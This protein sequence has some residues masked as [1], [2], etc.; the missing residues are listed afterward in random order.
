M[1][2]GAEEQG[3]RRV[4]AVSVVLKLSMRIHSDSDSDAPNAAYGAAH[5]IAGTCA[6]VVEHE[7][8][9]TAYTVKPSGE[10]APPPEAIGGWCVLVNPQGRAYPFILKDARAQG[11][12]AALWPVLVGGLMRSEAVEQAADHN[13]PDEGSPRPAREWCV[14]ATPGTHSDWRALSQPNAQAVLSTPG[15]YGAGWSR[16]AGLGRITQAWAEDVAARHNS[17]Q[18][19]RRFG[20]EPDPSTQAPPSDPG[21]APRDWSVLLGPAGETRAMLSS[22]VPGILWTSWPSQGWEHLAGYQGVPEAVARAR[23]DPETPASA[24]EPT[25]SRVRVEL[26]AGCGGVSVTVERD[27]V[28]VLITQPPSMGGV[29]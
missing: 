1:G 18:E 19:E 16:V 2:D 25:R 23:A 6:Y 24:A 26:P 3:E 27:D 10:P 29:L 15:Q 17:E 21:D 8:V 11:H 12:Y 28:E 7:V 9:A 22:D 14:L 20:E 13:D 4:R 5:K